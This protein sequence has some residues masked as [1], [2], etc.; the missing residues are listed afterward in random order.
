MDNTF[1]IANV[2]PGKLNA[3]VKNIMKQTGVSDPNEAVRMINAGEVQISITKPKWTER[4]GV[5]YFS[6]ISD[7]TTGKQ[8]IPR[9]ESKG[10]GVNDCASSG[11]CSKSFK[12]TNGINYEVAVLKAE[13]FSD[14]KRNTKN[15]RKDAKN[16]KLTTPSAEIACLIREKFSDKELEVMGLSWI[17]AMHEPIKDLNVVPMLLHVARCENG[18]WLDMNYSNQDY[19]FHRSTGF[20][21]VL[22]QVSG[23]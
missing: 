18:S 8:W 19:C 13:L 14:N 4:D 15:I 10:F 22:N 9:L 6:V 11:L 12:P 5:I 20:A 21:F 23:F 2:L 17:V 1:V 16:R 7:G 3:M